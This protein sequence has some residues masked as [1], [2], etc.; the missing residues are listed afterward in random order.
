MFS[1]LTEAVPAAVYYDLPRLLQAD[2]DID[3]TKPSDIVQVGRRTAAFT[4]L[5]EKSK[6]KYR[7]LR[8]GR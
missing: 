2:V 7:N 4:A 8:H 5:T 3:T 1:Y 6:K